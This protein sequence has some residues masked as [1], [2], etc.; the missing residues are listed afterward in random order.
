M[1][2]NNTWP[3][4]TI[5]FASL[6]TSIQVFPFPSPQFKMNA[7]FSGFEK[8][9][10]HLP[11]LYFCIFLICAPHL[12]FLLSFLSGY[13]SDWHL[14]L[15]SLCLPPLSRSMLPFCL[16]PLFHPTN[17]PRLPASTILKNSTVLPT[18]K[19]LSFGT[20][21]TRA[22]SLIARPFCFPLLSFL[23]SFAPP[24]GP[25]VCSSFSLFLSQTR[26]VSFY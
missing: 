15:L 25:V 10:F 21:L 9:I 6:L 1:L 4:V 18:S 19:Q 24:R 5:S 16:L 3:L 7:C 20:S 2:C 13:S 23:F 26:Y 14:H 17:S 11:P 22:P 12:E 8:P